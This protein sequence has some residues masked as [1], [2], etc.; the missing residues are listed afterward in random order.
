[1][2]EWTS[3]LDLHHCDEPDSEAHNS[4]DAHDHP[5]QRRR[6]LGDI[7]QNDLKKSESAL[8]NKELLT[9]FSNTIMRGMNSTIAFTLL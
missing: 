1:M 7:G 8:W 4:C 5:E 2:C 9:S 6:Q 3:G